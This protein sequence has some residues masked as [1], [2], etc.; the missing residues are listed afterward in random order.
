MSLGVQIRAVS[1][2]GDMTLWDF[3]KVMHRSLA[4]VLAELPDLVWHRG[5]NAGTSDSRSA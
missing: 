2:D 3:E 5:M 4:L 1:S